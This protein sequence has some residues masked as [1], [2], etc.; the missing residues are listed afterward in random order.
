M[1]TLGRVS[2]FNVQKQFGFVKLDDRQGDAFLHMKVLKEA[3]FYS[4]P[5]GTTVQVKVEPDR[6]KYKVI[7]V[8]KVDT[9]TARHGEPPAHARGSND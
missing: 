2:W 7:Q 1:I 9:S 8:L 3:G 5:R 6:G 4:V